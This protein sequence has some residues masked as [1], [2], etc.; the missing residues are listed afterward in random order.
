MSPLSILQGEFW[1]HVL[2]LSVLWSGCLVVVYG[3]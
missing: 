2:K 1:A 3:H